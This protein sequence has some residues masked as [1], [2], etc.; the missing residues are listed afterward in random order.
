M[1]KI[2]T[3]RIIDTETL[4]AMDA[5]FLA[6]AYDKLD[7]PEVPTLDLTSD[8]FERNFDWLNEP[9][10]DT[11]IEK[12]FASMKRKELADWYAVAGRDLRK[13]ALGGSLAGGTDDQVFGSW[14]TNR[15]A[16]LC[17]SAGAEGNSILATIGAAASPDSKIIQSIGSFLQSRPEFSKFE[18]EQIVA[19]ALIAFHWQ[20]A[21]KPS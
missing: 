13:I 6:G 8:P 20:K 4:A 7:Y 21:A 14:A 5:E 10:E 9:V 2:E 12:A 16:S 3:R 1:S 18:P 19:T 11:P 15:F 17:K